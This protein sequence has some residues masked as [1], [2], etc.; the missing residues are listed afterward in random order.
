[1]LDLVAVLVITY[2]GLCVGTF[3]RISDLNRSILNKLC[4][5]VFAPVPVFLVLVWV[6]TSIAKEK[7]NTLE[8]FCGYPLLLALS[9]AMYADAVTILTSNSKK[10]KRTIV[11]RYKYSFPI[12]K[13]AIV[14]NYVAA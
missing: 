11:Y 9:L 5:A 12:I 8:D 2:A 14:T 13:K 1:M 4:I 10:S 7:F 3:I 6:A